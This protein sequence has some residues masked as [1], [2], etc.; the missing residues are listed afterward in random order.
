MLDTQ[1]RRFVLRVNTKAEVVRPR[2]RN[3]ARCPSV[4]VII[5][6][7][8]YGRYLTQCVS[9][10]LDQRGVR[11]D[12]IVI[13][14]A[15]TDGSDQIVRRLGARDVRIRTTC[16][17][18]NQGHIAT[19]NEGLAQAIGDYSV[20]LSADDLLTPGCLARATSLMEE[21]P[22]VGL[23]Y[24]HAIEFA[25]GDLPAARTSAKSWI[26][27]QGH[28]WIMQRCKAGG[29]ALKSPEAVLRTS[30]LRQIGGYRADLPHAADFELW[31]RA[32]AVSDV[33]YVAGAD[34]AYY[35]S[36]AHNMH[37]SAFSMLDDYSQRLACF[38]V[39]LS[40]RPGLLKGPGSMRDTAHR[41]L[42][43]NALS[44]AIRDTG[45]RALARSSLYHLVRPYL[46]GAAG[47][48]PAGDYAAFALKAWPEARQLREWRAVDK[49]INA[50]DS[51]PG[52]DP[53]LLT[54][55]AIRKLRSRY[56][57]WRWKMTGI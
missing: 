5:P 9:S 51:P 40:E 23:T 43:R 15:S 56:A 1:M 52:L 16:H 48:Q 46:R 8:N 31:M 33:G 19:Y 47:D 41:A 39:A 36:H 13:D 10:V 37:Q 3:D 7:Y 21:Y 29:N 49:L 14:D 27:W 55:I 32:A 2:Q 38:D 11:V 30:V 22:S 44:D 18:V 20:L 53:P 17:A 42:A 12:V 50:P 6:C 25:D 45:H 54:R 24:G 28:D 35:R 4:S 26:V 34:Q 57:E